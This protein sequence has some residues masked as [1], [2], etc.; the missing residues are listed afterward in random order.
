MI[1]PWTETGPDQYS[2]FSGIFADIDRADMVGEW[3]HRFDFHYL[4]K[5]VHP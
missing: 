1:Q 4:H 5:D 2:D 3:F